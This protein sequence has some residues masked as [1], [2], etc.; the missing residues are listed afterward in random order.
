V[1]SPDFKTRCG[2]A[3]V[4][5]TCDP[6]VD[7]ETLEVAIQSMEDPLEAGWH[8]WIMFLLGLSFPAAALVYISSRLPRF[9]S[10]ARALASYILYRNGIKIE[11]SE[12][13]HLLEWFPGIVYTEAVEFRDPSVRQVLVDM[14]EKN[15]SV[16]AAGVLLRYHAEGLPVD[17]LA[18]CVTLVRPG[19]LW[20]PVPLE[21]QIK[22]M[23]DDPEFARAVAQSSGRIVAQGGARPLVDLFR[24]ALRDESG[25]Q[26]VVWSFLCDD[27]RPGGLS[28]TE[29][30]G[31]WL[32]DYARLCPRHSG[33]IGQAAQKLLYDPR[34]VGSPRAEP[35]QWLAILA[36]E[37]SNLSSEEMEKVLTSGVP[38]RRSAA[39]ALL[40]RVGHVPAGF[41]K[42]MAPRGPAA[43]PSFTAPPPG[44]KAPLADQIRS[45]K[46]LARQSGRLHPD[47]CRALGDLMLEDRLTE[48][49][50]LNLA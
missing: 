6:Q 13:E 31:Q 44:P 20:D 48:Q 16:S 50:L 23:E 28:E 11:R 3:A 15:Q 4:L 42:R 19:L 30:R 14:L 33:A 41:R 10:K 35:R 8:E 32:L 2:A 25:W 22:K 45:L 18:R 7:G 17:L 12:L 5:A 9:T 37:F 43:V 40:A 26:A 24:E 29:T 38:I 46:E 21:E 1:H 47:V 49:D 39:C 27:S 34:V 36:N